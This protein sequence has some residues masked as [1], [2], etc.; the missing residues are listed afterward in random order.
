[1]LRQ[2][3][4]PAVGWSGCDLCWLMDW[5]SHHMH[6]MN[7]SNHIVHMKCTKHELPRHPNDTPYV[8]QTSTSKKWQCSEMVRLTTGSPSFRLTHFLIFVAYNLKLIPWAKPWVLDLFI[9]GPFGPFCIRWNHVPIIVAHA[10]PMKPACSAKST[11]FLGAAIDLIDWW[12]NP[13][14]QN[15]RNHVKP[16]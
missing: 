10:F 6:W 7:K 8:L 4:S 15:P 16:C 13:F 3:K 14:L 5:Y 2:T 9:L 11:T 1:M 12:V